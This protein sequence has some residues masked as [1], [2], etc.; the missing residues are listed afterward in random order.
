MRL[1]LREVLVCLVTVMAVL[2]ATVIAV[3]AVATYSYYVHAT[4]PQRDATYRSA[5]VSAIVLGLASD[6]CLTEPAFSAR[7]VTPASE[8]GL[9]CPIYRS[10]DA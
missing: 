4:S 10:D 1:D 6:P 9:E 5:T 2:V 8:T 7:P 3:G